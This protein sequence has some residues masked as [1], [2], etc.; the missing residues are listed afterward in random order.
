ME[1][2]SLESVKYRRIHRDGAVLC[3]YSKPTTDKLH[4]K[5]NESCTKEELSGLV[6]KNI[7]SRYSISQKDIN[8]FALYF[9]FPFGG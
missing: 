2:G 8:W 9:S 1:S 4:T 7:T 5:L 3:I 6:N